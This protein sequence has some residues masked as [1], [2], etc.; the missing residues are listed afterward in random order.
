MRRQLVPKP[1]VGKG[2]SHHHL[3]I[4]PAGAV[5]IEVECLHAFR[6]EP[7]PRRTHRRNGTRRR[8][9]ICCDRIAQ[10]GEDLSTGDWA[11]AWW[12]QRHPVEERRILYV[13]RTL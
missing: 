12:H 9:V 11:N 4:T 7:F 10:F 3:V 1:D 2:A 13:S 6:D 5:R 8:D